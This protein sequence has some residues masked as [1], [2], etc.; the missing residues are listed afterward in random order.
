[1]LKDSEI[2]DRLAS[3]LEGKLSQDDFEDWLVQNTWNMHKD[4][5]EA[6]V[7]LAHAI[8]LRLA[9]HSSGHLTDDELRRELLPFAR[10]YAIQVVAAQRL[11][12]YVFSSSWAGNSAAA[13]R[14]PT[15]R[16]QSQSS[17]RSPSGLFSSVVDLGA[18]R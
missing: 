8:E 5:D 2:R 13:L 18:I 15:M 1:M 14:F 11:V 4:A 16:V 17:G 12:S 10:R 7:K 3:F 6:A 9:E